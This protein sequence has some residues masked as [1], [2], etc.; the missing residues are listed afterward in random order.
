MT[1]SGLSINNYQLQYQLLKPE[2]DVADSGTQRQDIAAIATPA[3][4]PAAQQAPKQQ[5]QQDETSKQ[6]QAFLSQLMEQ[7]LANRI[8]LDKQKYDE[9][10]EKIAE[11]EAEIDA[12]KRQ[13]QSPERDGKIA[14][15]EAKLE[16]LGKALEG[17]IA[18]ANRNREAKEREQQSI[19]AAQQYQ[20]TAATDKEPKLFL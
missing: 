10:K 2:T 17:L 11:A 7:M 15:L 1:V 3:A 8:G 14:V 5:Q 13:P 12:L 16:K 18:E 9:I 6:Q 20:L 19:N 4:T